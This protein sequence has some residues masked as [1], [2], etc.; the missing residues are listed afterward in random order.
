MSNGKLLINIVID[1]TA[2]MKGNKIEKL[3]KELHQFDHTLK[4]LSLDNDIKYSVT[5]CKGIEACVIKDFNE[6]LNINAIYIG[7]IPFVNELVTVSINNLL[8]EIEK[9]QDDVLYKP[10]TILLLNGENSGDVTSCTE[11]LLDVLKNGKMSYFPFALT[12]CEFNETMANIK[13][14]KSFTTIK[15]EMY[16]E[17]FN[18]IMNLAKNRVETPKG[19]AIPLDSKLLERWTVK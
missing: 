10:W 3:L 19:I 4:S 11:L 16:N 18:W 17:L 1:N 5:I 8:N 14:I 7:G 2:S 6:D 9:Y 12:D 13:R 15:D